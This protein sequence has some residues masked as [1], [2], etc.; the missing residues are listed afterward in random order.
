MSA[1]W[2]TPSESETPLKPPPAYSA[3]PFPSSNAARAIGVP[4]KVPPK[5]VHFT[6]RPLVWAAAWSAGPLPS[7][8]EARA[9]TEPLIPPPTADQVAPFHFA[10]WSAPLPPAV[11]NWP[12]A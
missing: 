5:R 4:W 11:V 12:P 6:T 2:T 8:S 9:K 3:G 7:S 10:T 1:A